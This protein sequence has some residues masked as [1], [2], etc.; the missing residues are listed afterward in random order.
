MQNRPERG[1]FYCNPG[2]RRFGKNRTAE[3]EVP[4]PEVQG[5]VRT[6]DFPVDNSLLRDTPVRFLKNRDLASVIELML[7]HSVQH[8]GNVVALAR[9]M[10]AQSLLGQCRDGSNQIQVRPSKQ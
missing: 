2:E 5:P 1:R 3:A 9:D 8:E 10:I 4:R 7:Q 6:F